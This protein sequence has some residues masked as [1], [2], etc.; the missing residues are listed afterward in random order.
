MELGWLIICLVYGFALLLGAVL[1]IFAAVVGFVLLIGSI[2]VLKDL[3]GKS[4]RR[5]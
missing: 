4:N 5:N 1:L 2:Q 3:H